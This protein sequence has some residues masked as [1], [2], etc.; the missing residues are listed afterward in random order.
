[1]DEV[2]QG[3]CRRGIS[4]TVNAKP[5]DRGGGGHTPPLSQ[6]LDME[7]V[8]AVT[9]A[10]FKYCTLG[11]EMPFSLVLLLPLLEEDSDFRLQFALA[12]SPPG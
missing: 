9:T 7:L 2:K 12:V 8:D 6:H 3:L 5:G 1:M 10:R 4:T 11:P